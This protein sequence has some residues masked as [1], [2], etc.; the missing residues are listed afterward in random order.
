MT[1]VNIEKNEIVEHS[2]LFGKGNPSKAIF[3]LIPSENETTVIWGVEMNMGKFPMGR[4][5]G[6]ILKK[7][8]FNDFTQGLENLKMKIENNTI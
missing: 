4:I 7:M 2:L 3:K 5:I 6:S 8:L 1:I